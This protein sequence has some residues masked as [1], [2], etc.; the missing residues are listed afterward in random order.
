[1][2]ATLMSVRSQSEHLRS[3]YR[4]YRYAYLSA[5]Q[6]AEIAINAEETALWEQLSKAY[7]T[8]DEEG[9]RRL[10]RLPIFV[11]VVLTSGAE[12]AQGIAVDISGGGVF[13]LSALAK[14]EGDA[15]QIHFQRPKQSD[16][17]FTGI[18][19]RRCV[20]LGNAGL[21]IRFEGVPMAIDRCR[22]VAMGD[23]T[24]SCPI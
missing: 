11:P 23:L 19:V 8:H 22:G 3:V 13:V 1:M 12:V 5:T 2:H 18:I 7:E 17:V 16:L 20:E 4:C 15:V 9:G 14:S 24:L 6:E 21:G 10:K